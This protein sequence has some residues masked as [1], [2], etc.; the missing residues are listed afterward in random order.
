MLGLLVRIMLLVIIFPEVTSAIVNQD[1]QA[2]TV[3]QVNE[4]FKDRGHKDVI[5]HFWEHRSISLFD[6]SIKNHFD[7]LVYVCNL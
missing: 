3:R 1:L 2:E 4:I 5:L 6:L 7:F